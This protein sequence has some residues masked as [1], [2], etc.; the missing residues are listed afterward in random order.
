MLHDD[1]E[2]E[3]DKGEE[4]QDREHDPSTDVGEDANDLLVVLGQIHM[5]VISASQERLYLEIYMKYT[6]IIC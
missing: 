5:F 3:I 1:S 2:C 6:N 4:D